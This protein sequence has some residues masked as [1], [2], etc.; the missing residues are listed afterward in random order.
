MRF[1]YDRNEVRCLNRKGFTLI[2]ILAVMVILSVII[3]ISIQRF[4]L[5]ADNTIKK[6][7][8][9]AIRELNIRETL[10]W[11]Q[12]KLSTAGYPGDEAVFKQVDKNLGQGFYWDPAADTGGG[13]LQYGSA[14]IDLLRTPSTNTSAGSWR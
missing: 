14:S 3:S 1:P 11:T 13:S 7:L 8:A 10:V 5:L 4:D 6:I 9:T 2:E 12:F